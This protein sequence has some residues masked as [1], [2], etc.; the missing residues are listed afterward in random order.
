[1]PN[2]FYAGSQGALLTRYD[3][4]TGH[5]RDVQVYPLFFSGMSSSVLKERWQWTFPIVFNPARS[6]NSLYVVAAFVED[7]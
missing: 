7:H 1:M 4:A 3:R 5:M 2:I 6:E